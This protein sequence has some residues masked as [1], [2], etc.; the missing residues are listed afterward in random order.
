MDGCNDYASSADLAPF[1]VEA[2]P[3]ALELRLVRETNARDWK[4]IGA[5]V[6]VAGISAAVSRRP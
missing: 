6:D 3:G 2:G 1:A 5:L 4:P